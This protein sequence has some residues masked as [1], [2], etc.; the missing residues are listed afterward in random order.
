MRWGRL[1]RHVV[2]CFYL[3]WV[4]SRLLLGLC[5]VVIVGE[6]LWV[7]AIGGGCLLLSACC[8]LDFK[9]CVCCFEFA[10]LWGLVVGDFWCFTY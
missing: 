8:V 6:F 5:D 10:I 3:G 9:G 2:W 7:F 1:V 4:Y